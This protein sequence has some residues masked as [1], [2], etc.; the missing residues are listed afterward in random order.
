M[1][2]IGSKKWLEERASSGV[3]DNVEFALCLDSLGGDELYLHVS[4]PPKDTAVQVIYDAFN[5]VAIQMEV[6]F[7]VAH[8]KINISHPDVFWEHEQFSRKRIISGTLSHRSSPHLP[9]ARP[10]LLDKEINTTALTRNIRYVGEVLARHAYGLEDA[11]LISGSYDVLEERIKAWV[12]T[13][14]STPRVAP[15][16]PKNFIDHLS[17]TLSKFTK[18]FAKESYPVDPDYLFFTPIQASMSA[19]RVKPII[20]DF[21]LTISIAVYLISLYA[22]LKGKDFIPSVREMFSSRSSKSELRKKKTT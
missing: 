5:E 17:S 9:Y 1:N 20:V 21:I 13:F 7:S 10:G 16:I 8:R 19:S 4:R 18:D 2:Y 22:F 3:L 12:D 14:K 6:P 15:Y 11:E